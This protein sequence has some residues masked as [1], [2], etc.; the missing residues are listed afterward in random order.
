M[1][2]H[3]GTQLLLQHKNAQTQSTMESYIRK[4]IIKVY[5]N[6]LSYPSF[7]SQNT[8]CM[9]LSNNIYD[10]C[11]QIPDNTNVHT[12]SS[13]YLFPTSLVEIN[14]ISQCVSARSTASKS[15]KIYRYGL[16]TDHKSTT[17]HVV[18]QLSSAIN[19]LLIN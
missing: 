9:L 10:M 17:T 6:D 15:N 2:N 1:P 3:W 18:S 12:L 4:S 13:L 11:M 7:T 14:S 8:G 5:I 19:N 16:R